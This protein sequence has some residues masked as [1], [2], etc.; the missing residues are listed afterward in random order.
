S[1][2]DGNTS[3]SISIASAALCASTREDATTTAIGSPAKRTISC[4]SSRRGGTVIG[5]PS[6]RMNT[7]SVGIV[8]TSSL[9]RSAPVNTAA[10]PFMSAAAFV[11]IALIFACACGERSTCSHNA[12]SS[13]LS[14]MKFP[15]PVS[16]R[17]SSRRLTGL[18]APKR[19]LPGRIFISL[20]FEFL[21]IALQVS[22]HVLERGLNGLALIGRQRSLRRHG[23]ADTIALDCKPGLDAGG[24][25]EAREGFVD[26]PE[27]SLQRH[28]LAP[29]LGLA[30]IVERNAL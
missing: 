11:L 24:E 13:G 5:L 14:S 6:G 8:P 16:R 3:Y 28:R 22:G 29:A 21:W 9:I 4:A 25:V 15:F 27:L 19:R 10:T 7:V 12:P 20:S 1:T 17:W 2:T 30:E 23:I 18:P 26:A